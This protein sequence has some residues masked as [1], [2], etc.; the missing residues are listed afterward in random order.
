MSL[1]PQKSDYT[2]CVEQGKHERQKEGGKGQNPPVVV[3]G[4]STDEM[5]TGW[6]TLI[7]GGAVNFK[8]HCY[9]GCCF[10]L[11]GISVAEVLALSP[12]LGRKSWGWKE[13]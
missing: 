9:W 2:S 1:E 6:V 4:E 5:E 13:S 12:H 3:K 8:V 7:S 11:I 10:R